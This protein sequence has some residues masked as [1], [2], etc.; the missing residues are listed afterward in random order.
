MARTRNQGEREKGLQL[1]GEISV[2]RNLLAK[3]NLSC[4]RY[5][6]F[7]QCHRPEGVSEQRDRSQRV[8]RLMP[9]GHNGQDDGGEAF[10]CS[11]AG[12]PGEGPLLGR[13]VRRAEPR[14]ASAS[15]VLHALRQ[16][17]SSLSCP[18]RFGGTREIF[19]GHF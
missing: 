17:T 6:A 3:G 15:D 7:G 11:H 9:S 18:V 5:L 12:L 1:S 13:T 16:N 19:I 14:W 10:L 2:R 8:C 4:E